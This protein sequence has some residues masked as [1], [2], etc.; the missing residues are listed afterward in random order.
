MRILADPNIDSGVPGDW[1]LVA[2][3]DALVSADIRALKTA[4]A[5]LIL[6]LGS[7]ALV[8]AA[9]TAGEFSKNDRLANGL[10]IPA[11]APPPEAITDLRELLGV[12]NFVSAKNSGVWSGGKS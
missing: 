5:D 9:V 2:F 4:Q 3:S 12:D 1:L 10:G 8:A 11:D 6:E 7:H